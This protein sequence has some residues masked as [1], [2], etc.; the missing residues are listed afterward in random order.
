MRRQHLGFTLIE[1]TLALAVAGVVAGIAIPAVT[2]TISAVHAAT[3][4]AAMVET[5]SK[6]LTHS[7]VTGAEVV[8]CP[9]SGGDACADTIDW[10]G[11]WIAFADLDGN[12]NR[13]PNETLLQQQ[14]ALTNGAHLR[15]TSGRKRLVFQPGGGAA[16]GSNVTFTLCDS[17]GVAKAT[18]LV[19]ANN[20]RFRQ[21][22][23]TADAAWACMQ[24]P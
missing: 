14:A 3:A 13:G 17:R 20:G 12:R 22:K 6:A 8:L 18:T 23:P 24:P 16:A 10:S 7:T 4:K 21:G 11:G 2:G 1:A 5:F 9:T 15:G 19:L